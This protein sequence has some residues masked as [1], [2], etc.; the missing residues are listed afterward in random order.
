MGS[1][2]KACGQDLPAG[3]EE[4]GIAVWNRV[5]KLLI[6]WDEGSIVLDPEH[7]YVLGRDPSADIPIENIKLSRAHLRLSFVNKAWELKDLDSSNGSF[8]NGKR[9]DTH[10]LVKA[11]TVFLG[12]SDNL[13]FTLTPL[14]TSTATTVKA[15][16]QAQDKEATRM[17]KVRGDE[18]LSEESGPRRVRLQHR[19]RIG[20]AEGSDWYIDCSELSRWV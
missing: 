6:E 11:A 20:R 18:Y 4:L 3:L 19:I 14:T 16:L 8:I 2:Y 1:L 9:F 7:S 17:T 15:S 13:S 5:M 12:G 10:K